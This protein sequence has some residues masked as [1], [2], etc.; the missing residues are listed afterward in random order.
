MRKKPTSLDDTRMIGLNTLISCHGAEHALDAYHKN[1]ERV[2]L[3][4]EP[5]AERY[6]RLYLWY[7][8]ELKRGDNFIDVPAAIR[9]L[10]EA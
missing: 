4:V 8:R 2:E 5:W 10:D 1:C 3:P 9:A 7:R 6:L